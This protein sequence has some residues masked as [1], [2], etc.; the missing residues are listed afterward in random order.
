[1]PKKNQ[2][3]N[4]KKNPSNGVADDGLDA[5]TKKR[6]QRERTASGKSVELLYDLFPFL[7][8]YIHSYTQA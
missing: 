5:S 3:K 7:R 6:D 1:M 8:I 4:Q 2:K